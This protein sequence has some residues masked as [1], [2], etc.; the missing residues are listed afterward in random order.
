[1]SYYRVFGAKRRKG[2]TRKHEKITIW[3]VFVWRP[4]QRYDK[5]GRKRKRSPRVYTTW[6]KLATI[7][8]GFATYSVNIHYY[9]K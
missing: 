3:R 8:P 4:L 9:T 5:Q 6:H 2:A 1:M 7:H